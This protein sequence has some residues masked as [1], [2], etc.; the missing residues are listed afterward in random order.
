MDRIDPLDLLWRKRNYS[1]V[2]LHAL[3]IRRAGV[4]RDAFCDGPGEDHL[5][6]RRVLGDFLNLGVLE[7][8]RALAETAGAGDF[9]SGLEWGVTAY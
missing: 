2:L 9:V 7:Q 1:D 6:C 8:F 3:L 4:D 5:A